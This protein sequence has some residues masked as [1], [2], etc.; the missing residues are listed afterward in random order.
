MEKNYSQLDKEGLS[1]IFGVNKFNQYLY[2]TQF[3]L[4]TD[5]CLLLGLFDENRP[6]PHNASG[7]I[8]RWALVLAGY[9]YTISGVAPENCD[10][11]S[12]LSL[13]TKLIVT[14]SPAEYVVLIEQLNESPVTAAHIHEWTIHDK[15]LSRVQRYIL[16]GWPANDP[17]TQEYSRFRD[18]LSMHDGCI[19]RGAKV[20]IPKKGQT[21]L[22]NCSTVV[23]VEWLRSG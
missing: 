3:T 8:Q 4:V 20:V 17:V 13:S 16:T 15:T 5:H 22:L 14:P 12:R 21:I 6:V 2:G 19:M 23:T 11:L 7:C 18:E 10:A 1:L 9:N